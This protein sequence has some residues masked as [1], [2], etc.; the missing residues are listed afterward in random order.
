MTIDEWLT[1]VTE[2]FSRANIPT[3]R[4]DAELILCHMLG[5]ERSW[6]IAHGADSLSRA[7]LMNP[8]GVRP[9][10]ISVYGNRLVLL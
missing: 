3:A 10:G 5:V 2:Q 4:L 1:D 8:K 7:A 9:G 6:L